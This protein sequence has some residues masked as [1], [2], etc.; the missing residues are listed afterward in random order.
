MA[1]HT[2]EF[3]G[4]H[5]KNPFVEETGRFKT[6]PA[7]H[8]GKIFNASSTKIAVDAL[9]DFCKAWKDYQSDWPMDKN[10]DELLSIDEFMKPFLEKVKKAL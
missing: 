9:N 1:K 3:E 4:V 5:I 6:T 10:D 2:F 7:K 8:Y